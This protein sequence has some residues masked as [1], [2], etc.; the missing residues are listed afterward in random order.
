[1]TADKPKA[2]EMAITRSDYLGSIPTKTDTE[3]DGSLDMSSQ[4]LPRRFFVGV[5]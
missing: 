4:G 1:M 5:Y 2:S 3:I